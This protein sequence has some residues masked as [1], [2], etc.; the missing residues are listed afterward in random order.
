M[1]VW[2]EMGA[3]L[4]V[5]DTADQAIEHDNPARRLMAAFLRARNEHT[6]RAYRKDLDVLAKF[7]KVPGREEAAERLLQMTGGRANELA[8]NFQGSLVEAGRSP[9]TVNRRLSTLRALTKLGRMLGMISWKIEIDN[10]DTAVYRDTRGPGELAVRRML[11]Q[12]PSSAKGIRD[13]AMVHLM[14]DMGLR[15]GE[16]TGLDVKHW[17]PERGAL[18]VLGKKRKDREWLSIPASTRQALE[19]WLEI[20]GDEP[21][22]MFQALD[23]KNYGH[24]LT[25]AAVFSIIRKLGRRVGVKT[26][27]HGLRHAAI[28]A[29]LDKNGGDLRKAARFSRHRSLDTLQ[30]YDDNRRD[31][32]G[33]MA[34]LVALPHVPA[35]GGSKPPRGLQKPSGGPS[36]PHWEAFVAWVRQEL[37]GV[38]PTEVTAEELATFV[39]DYRGDRRAAWLVLGKLRPWLEDEVATMK[40]VLGV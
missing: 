32:G 25:G 16:L 33:Q 13:T 21:G 29:V 17:D 38:A 22:A 23:R 7:M 6:L 37:S 39:R 36:G 24:R 15:R 1:H 19:A 8:L 20:R 10:L 35:P 18:S 34:E 40:S 30:M 5:A 27:P 26:R 4:V 2:P 14:Y 28:T 12:L 3:D 31:L 11:E 9:A